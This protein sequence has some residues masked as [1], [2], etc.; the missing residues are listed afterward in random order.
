MHIISRKKL[1]EFWD[2]EKEAESPLDN[3]FRTAK[4]A[5]WKNLSEIRAVY[6]H[7]DLFGNCVIF[8]IGG[9]KYRLITYI[10]FRVRRVYVLHVLTHKEYDKDAWKKSCDC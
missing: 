5:G 8:N 4:Q 6:S 3:W 10:N 9:N 7:A 1:R 2:V